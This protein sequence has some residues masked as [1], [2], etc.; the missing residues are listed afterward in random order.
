MFRPHRQGGG[1]EGGAQARTRKRR[2]RPASVLARARVRED[3]DMRRAFSVLIVAALVGIGPAAAQTLS[4]P[5]ADP[6]ISVVGEGIVR[7]QPDMAVVTAGVVSEAETAGAALGDNSAVMG[8]MSEALRGAGIDPR[9]LQTAGFFVE[10]IW[11]QPPRDFDGSQP[12][13]PQIVGYRVRN[14]LTIRIRNLSRTGAILDQLVSLGANSISGPT[15]T[16]ADP[17]P[18]ED[19]ARRAAVRDALRKGRLYA[20]AASVPLGAILRIEENVF[21]RPQPMPMQAMAREQ[22]FDAAVPIEAGEITFEA[23]VDVTWRIG[24]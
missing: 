6:S 22:A 1:G 21:Q 20:D 4:L 19:Q 13:E 9:D 17:T 24:E 7:G 3:E 16:V 12:F 14:E 11:S 8:R 10:P 23:R 15:F 5:P 18:L 2:I